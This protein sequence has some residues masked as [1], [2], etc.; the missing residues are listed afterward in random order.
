MVEEFQR[1]DLQKGRNSMAISD[2]DESDDE[3]RNDG[4]PLD[5]FDD[6]DFEENYED[7]EE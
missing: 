3:W 5:H 7:V 2:L 4:D 1:A 6:S